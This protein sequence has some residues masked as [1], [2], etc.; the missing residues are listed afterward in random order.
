MST[1]EYTVTKLVL[2][3]FYYCS[4]T[5]KQYRT[6]RKSWCMCVCKKC[7]KSQ[8]FFTRLI[9]LNQLKKE[10]NQ[11]AKGSDREAKKDCN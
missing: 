6:H 8:N 11:T 1:V 4:S 7:P 9:Y 10:T 3:M 2:A 5:E